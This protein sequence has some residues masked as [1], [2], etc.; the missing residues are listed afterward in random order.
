MHVPPQSYSP[1]RAD[2]WACGQLLLHM[3]SR[4]YVRDPAPLK[5]A[6]DLSSDDPLR[7]PLLYGHSKTDKH[8]IPHLLDMPPPKRILDRPGSIQYYEGNSVIL[9]LFGWSTK[10]KH[11]VDVEVDVYK[12]WVKH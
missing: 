12:L 9:R 8:S 10:D 5:L 2:L 1:I 4:S 7:R 3:G 6:R 11:A